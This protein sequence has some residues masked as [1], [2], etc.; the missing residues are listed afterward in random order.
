MRRNWLTAFCIGSALILWLL[1][2]II[3]GESPVTD[4]ATLSDVNLA[5]ESQEQAHIARVRAEVRHAQSRKRFLT[6]R[7]R[8]HSK[9]IVDVKAE[10]AGKVVARPIERGARVAQGDLLCE[11]ALDDRQVALTETKAA[12]NEA[13]IEHEGSLKLKAR[14]LQSQTAIARSEAALEFARANVLRA[15]LNLARTRIVAPFDGV[16]EN[17]PLN[18]GDY[19]TNGS[20]CAT[21]IDLDPMLITADV[22]EAEVG[23]VELATPVVGSTSAG[24]EI[25]GEIT[26][27][28]K[29][30]DP[31]TRTY[32]VEA[33]VE[34]ADYSLSSG[35][36]TSMRIE[37]NEVLAHRVSPALFTLD[38]AGALGVRAIDQ[39]NRVVFYAVDVIEDTAEGAWVT[40]LPSAVNLITVGQ[41]FVL[42]GQ[43]VEPIYVGAQVDSAIKV[44]SVNVAPVRQASTQ[45]DV[46]TPSASVDEPALVSSTVPMGST[47]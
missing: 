10:L 11:L 39:D 29:Q 24:V 8:M 46:N 45:L 21:V 17:L 5:R 20:L 1:S 37:L 43:L 31:L 22:T 32:S 35:L 14:G 38:D 16:V 42:V 2:G 47:P 3:F 41:E 15:E 36:T 28:S 7:G 4:H 18:I 44:G 33:T 13:E 40:G 34:N 30:S 25:L 27:V 6:L 23:Y 12:L 9:R 19:A 26:F